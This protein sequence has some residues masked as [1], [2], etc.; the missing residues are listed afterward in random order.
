M[1]GVTVKPY[2]QC[3]VVLFLSHIFTVYSYLHNNNINFHGGLLFSADSSAN[4]AILDF[5]ETIIC[6]IFSNFTNSVRHYGSWKFLIYIVIV[7]RENVRHPTLCSVITGNTVEISGM[8]V[9]AFK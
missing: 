1:D 6:T 7:K 4:T 2:E 8:M 3:G 9:I 5:A